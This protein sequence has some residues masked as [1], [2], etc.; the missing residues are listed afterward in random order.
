MAIK[1]KNPIAVTAA[2]SKLEK[3]LEID[4][5][6]NIHFNPA[7]LEDK[8]DKYVVPKEVIEAISE[9]FKTGIV[10]FNKLEIEDVEA[11]EIKN[12]EEQ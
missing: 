8:P 7:K 2:L 3:Y 11:E 6:E 4:K 9:H 10:D 5:T 1:Q 12:D